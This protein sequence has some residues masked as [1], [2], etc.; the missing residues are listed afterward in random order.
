MSRSTTTRTVLLVPAVAAALLAAPPA[1]ASQPVTAFGGVWI[2]GWGATTATVCAYGEVDDGAYI[3]GVWTFTVVGLRADGLPSTDMST[4]HV[5][6]TFGD[7]L[8]VTTGALLACV[9]GTLTY[10][11]AG[12]ADVTTVAGLVG[13]RTAATTPFAIQ[14]TTSG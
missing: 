2:G 7:C 6:P 8:T 12:T 4:P 3:A 14:Y 1:H 10:V 5:G 9:K 13:V 11:G